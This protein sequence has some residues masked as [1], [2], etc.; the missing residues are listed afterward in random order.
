MTDNEIIKA[1]ECC[2]SDNFGECEYCPLKNELDEVFTCMRSKQKL[3]IDLLKRKDA[4]IERLI[5]MHS[6]MCIGIKK[7][8][9]F[10]IKEFAERLCDG[11]LLGDPVLIAVRAELKNTTEPVKIEHNSLC[12]TETYMGE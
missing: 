2:F 1:L 12:E 4:E 3:A 7:L 10:A 6:E 5:P 9:E 8:K 11:R